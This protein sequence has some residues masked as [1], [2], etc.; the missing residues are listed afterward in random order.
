MKIE[1]LLVL[2]LIGCSSVQESKPVA[3]AQSAPFVRHIT[4]KTH[5]L[6]TYKLRTERATGYELAE[7]D[8][9]Q[10]CQ[11]KWGLRSYESIQPNCV[12]NDKNQ[13]MCSVTFAC[14]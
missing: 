11:T 6:Y 1:H 3:T 13:V 12:T 7:A 14:R 5:L 8:A 2:A 9:A 10:V 4:S